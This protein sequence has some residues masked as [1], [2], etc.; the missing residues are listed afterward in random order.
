MVKLCKFACFA[1]VTTHALKKRVCVQG[2]YAQAEAT[3][4][5]ATFNREERLHLA[6][7]TALRVNFGVR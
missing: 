5:A 2:F 6:R 1:L 7:P 4:G 3:L